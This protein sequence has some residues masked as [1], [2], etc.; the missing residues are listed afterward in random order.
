MYF[1]FDT[2]VFNIADICGGEYYA[3]I[4]SHK[5]S[6]DGYDILMFTEKAD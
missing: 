1:E 2:C 6:K 4:N 5:H 3:D